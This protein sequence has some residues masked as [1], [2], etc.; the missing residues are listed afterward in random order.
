MWVLGMEP[1]YLYLLGHLA[2]PDFPRFENTGR[3][4]YQRSNLFW[5]DIILT[6]YV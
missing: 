6:K 3:T 1:G 2:D 4:R 5:N